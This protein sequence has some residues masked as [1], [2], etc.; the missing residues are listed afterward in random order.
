MKDGG[1]EAFMRSASCHAERFEED[2][3]SQVKIQLFAWGLTLQGPLG[4]S[5]GSKRFQASETEAT[6]K[7]LIVWLSPPIVKLWKLR[8][9]S[10]RD[11]SYTS[12]FVCYF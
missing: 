5:E 3:N 2:S 12:K 10:W 7:V 4:G 1:P 11:G 9:A 6:Y 8:Q